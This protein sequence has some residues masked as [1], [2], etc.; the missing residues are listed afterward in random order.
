MQGGHTGCM[1][2]PNQR[3]LTSHRDKNRL[4][5]GRYRVQLTYTLND[6]IIQ[7]IQAVLEYCFLCSKTTKQYRTGT[8]THRSGNLPTSSAMACCPVNRVD[9]GT[10]QQSNILYRV[11]T[12]QMTAS[13]TAQPQTQRD[14]P[15][16]TNH[17]VLRPHVDLLYSRASCVFDSTIRARL[18]ALTE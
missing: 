18:R 3:D 16:V 13:S 2:R 1:A 12:I 11:I 10:V 5:R 9:T 7:I 6:S 4:L 14:L 8:A 17:Y 15:V